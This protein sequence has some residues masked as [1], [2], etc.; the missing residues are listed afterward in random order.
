MP[1]VPNQNQPPSTSTIDLDSGHS[2]DS[3]HQSPP[4]PPP[5]VTT[6][7]PNSRFSTLSSGLSTQSSI[8]CLSNGQIEVQP[9]N[10]QK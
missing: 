9:A 7:P 2:S 8:S 1:S 5:P 10:E 3:E 6:N 4:P